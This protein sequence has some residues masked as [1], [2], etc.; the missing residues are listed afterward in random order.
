MYKYDFLQME[1]EEPH[2]FNAVAFSWNY[3]TV[4][5]QSMKNELKCQFIFWNTLKCT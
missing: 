2:Y 1:R 3:A 5:I 4:I